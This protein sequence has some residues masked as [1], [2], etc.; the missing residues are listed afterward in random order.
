M[1][2]QFCISGLSSTPNPPAN[3]AA[4]PEVYDW[5]RS[6][7]PTM[8]WRQNGFRSVR[9]IAECRMG[10]DDIECPRQCSEFD[11]YVFPTKK[12]FRIA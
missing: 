2:G 6:V 12:R 4:S 9:P 8:G 1:Y 10:P 11:L 3:K 5:K 7:G